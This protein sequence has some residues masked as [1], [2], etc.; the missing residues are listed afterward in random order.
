[1]CVTPQP[2]PT[3]KQ[4]KELDQKKNLVGTKPLLATDMQLPVRSATKAPCEK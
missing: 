1:M 4:K 3:R 2:K